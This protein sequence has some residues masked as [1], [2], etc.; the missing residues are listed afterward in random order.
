MPTTRSDDAGRAGRILDATM[1][2]FVRFGYDKTTV[3]DIAREAGVGKGVIYSHFDGKEILLSALIEREGKRLAADWLRRVQ[4]DPH[5]G[6]VATIYRHSLLALA[7]HPFMR[8]LYT[9]QSYVLGEFIHQRDPAI[10]RRRYLASLDFTRRLQAAG[11]VRSDLSAEVVNHMFMV[12]ACGLVVIEDIMSGAP[13][14]SIEAVADGLA[15][16]M[17]RALG[18]PEVDS[19]VALA[20]FFEAMEAEEQGS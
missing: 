20:R 13:F 9:K 19:A 14:P 2:L 1:R 16:V 12:I 11:V 15:I 3:A 18:T 17:Q 6:T 10:Y 5:G 7:E 4:G 8:A